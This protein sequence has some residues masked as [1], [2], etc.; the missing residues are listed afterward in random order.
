M[1]VLGSHGHGG[2]EGFIHGETVASVHHSV[3]IPLLIVPSSGTEP[4]LQPFEKE[5]VERGRH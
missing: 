2:I 4:A 3:R 5:A 1:L